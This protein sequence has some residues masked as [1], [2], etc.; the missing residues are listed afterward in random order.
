LKMKVALA[1]DAPALPSRAYPKSAGY[2]LRSAERTILYAGVTT[3]I[4]TGVKLQLPENTSGQIWPRSGLA[5]MG[6]SVRG[7]VDEDF[8]GE[9][10]VVMQNNTLLDVEIEEGT[11][12]AQL[13]IVPV[14]H[15]KMDIVKELDE[16]SRGEQGF[17][18]SDKADRQE[19]HGEILLH[20]IVPLTVD[21]KQMSLLPKRHKYP[22]MVLTPENVYMA[23]QLAFGSSGHFLAGDEQ[24]K[25]ILKDTLV[26]NFYFNTQKEINVAEQL[27]KDRDEVR[28]AN[29]AHVQRALRKNQPSPI[30]QD[31]DA[32]D[33]SVKGQ[34]EVDSTMETESDKADGLKAKRNKKDTKDAEDHQNREN[35]AE[36]KS[37]SP[38]SQRK[39][40]NK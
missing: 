35:E 3:P 19:E 8:R 1:T 21:P 12:I 20:D 17:G 4:R 32:V 39:V 10:I 27:L 37:F 15:P 9:I 6:F 28:E 18:S 36:K 11:K 16:S 38:S 22:K 31:E 7:I 33:M 30:P 25:E 29:L 40:A 34:N 13:L 14:I 24:T 2:D 26:Q 5:K 23:R